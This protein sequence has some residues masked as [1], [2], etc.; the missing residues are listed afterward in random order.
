MQMYC[1]V[2]MKLLVIGKYSPDM[3]RFDAD[4]GEAM[5][6]FSEKHYG[7][8]RRP[9]NSG[10][11]WFGFRTENDNDGLRTRYT[12]AGDYLMRELKGAY[13]GACTAN[14]PPTDK[15]GC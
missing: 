15:S 11:G 14:V 10:K 12:P 4:I 8:S 2:C 6:R 7:C 9:T 3:W 1:K 13:D 5:G